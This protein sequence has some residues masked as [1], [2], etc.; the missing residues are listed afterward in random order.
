MESSRFFLYR[1]FDM[2]ENNRKQ[3]VKDMLNAETW[4][5]TNEYHVKACLELV[6]LSY[7]RIAMIHL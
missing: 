7:L 4:Q 6:S 1:V 3:A 2:V 5:A